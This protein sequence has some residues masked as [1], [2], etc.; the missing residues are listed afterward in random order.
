MLFSGIK[1]FYFWAMKFSAGQIAEILGGKVEGDENTEVDRLAKIEEGEAG[2]LTFL[3]N[4]AYTPYI[5]NTKA[6]IV[7]VQEDFVSE[8]PIG[9]NTTLIRVSDAYSSFGKLLELYDTA[10]HYRTG[11]EEKARFADSAK[12]GENIYL[13][14]CSYIGENVVVGDNVKIYPNVYIADNV[15]IG[16]NTIIY[17]SVNIYTDCHIGNSCIL[18]SGVVIGGDGFGF[19]LT[20]ENQYKKLAQIGNVIIED[21]V[22]IGC[23]TTVDRATMGSTIIRKG[24]KL[25]NLVQIGHNAE[26]GEHTVI[27]AQTG[28][29]GSSKVGK[30]CMIGGQVGITGH[31]TIGDNVKIAAQSGVISSIDDNEVV[32]GSPA[33]RFSEYNRAYVY[34]KGLRKIVSR[35]TDLENKFKRNFTEEDER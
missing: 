12:L 35:I 6:S 4:L 16:H 9:K 7:I 30:N 22:E 3:S 18:H 21:N 10:K 26:V 15:K 8:K 20:D 27:A 5:Y 13:G 11:I 24:V 14:S 17:P 29:A 2:S 34:F 1:I 23:N 32:Q 25:D 33:F 19:S 31:I 28:I